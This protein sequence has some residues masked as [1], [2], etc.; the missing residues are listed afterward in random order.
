[1]TDIFKVYKAIEQRND[2]GAVDQLFDLLDEEGNVLTLDEQG[3]IIEPSGRKTPRNAEP[4][5]TVKRMTISD[6]SQEDSMQDMIPLKEWARINGI[7]AATARQKAGRG[8][9]KTARKVGRDWMI[10]RLEVNP[11]N[12]TRKVISVPENGFGPGAVLGYLRLIDGNSSVDTW[13]NIEE[14]R[15][16]CRKVFFSLRSKLTGNTKKLFDLLSDSIGDSTKKEVFYI[17]HDQ[18]IET[19]DDEAFTIADGDILDFKDYIKAL[20]NIVHDL[21]SYT[22]DLDLDKGGQCICLSWFRSLIWTK[23]Q[24]GGIYFV[25]SDFFRLIITGLR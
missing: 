10:S 16:Y 17:S 6:N 24:D 3:Q 9:L 11:D 13:K 5:N 19:L 21:L 2:E 1:M 7:S 25:P 22:I 14:H 8:G 20:S 12:R 23:S 4:R 18:L 15:D